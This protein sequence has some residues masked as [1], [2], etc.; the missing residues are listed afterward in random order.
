M[1]QRR[2]E[3]VF[4]GREVKYEVPFK[5]PIPFY[6]CKDNVPKGVR[7]NEIVLCEPQKS[8]NVNMLHFDRP[9]VCG[10]YLHQ[11]IRSLHCLLN[12]QFSDP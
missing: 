10:S 5:D 2:K 12:K 4:H 6:C 8:L 7:K 11:S 1:N 3:R 9:C